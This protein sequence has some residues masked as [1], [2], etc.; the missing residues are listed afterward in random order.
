[1]NIYKHTFLLTGASNEGGN[2]IIQDPVFSDERDGL[3]GDPSLDWPTIK[4]RYIERYCLSKKSCTI[5]NSKLLYDESISDSSVT[6][7]KRP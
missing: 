7:L 5:S 1:M 6:P 3:S 2:V 4:E